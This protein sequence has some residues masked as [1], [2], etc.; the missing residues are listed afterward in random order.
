MN[1]VRHITLPDGFVAGA[2][3]CG[4]KTTEREDIAIIAAECMPVNTA[5]VTTTNQVIGAPVRWCRRILPRGFGKTRAV[6]VNAGVSNVCNGARGDK[7]AAEMAQRTASALGCKPEE[8]LVC[9]TGVIGQPLPMDKIRRGID[10]AAA[11]LGA[12]DDD[13]VARAILTTDTRPKSAVVQGKIGRTTV[14]LAGIA[15]GSGMIAPS[16]AT[17]LSFITT[18][19]KISPRALATALRVSCDSTFN[20]ITVDGDTSTSDTVAAFAS[21]LAGNKSI[22]SGDDLAR[23]GK[24]LTEVCSALAE[25]IVRDGEGA[26][27]LVRIRVRNARTQGDAKAAARTIAN[28]LLLK[29]AVHGGDPNWGRI[30]AAAGR[31]EATVD[32]DQAS[33]RIGGIAV[34]RRGTSCKFDHDAVAEHMRGDT[35]EIELDLALGTGE[36]AALTCDLSRE[37][38]EINAEY[39]T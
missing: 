2:A 38:V 29:C 26:T 14:T 33:C 12:R 30:L 9:S 27:R 13:P 23:F 24:M 37:Y 20:A 35:V 19:A 28:S 36:Y 5:V 3:R 1:E 11:G 16:M 15:K 17:M 39:H 32:Q 7:D 25:S 31:S 10:D 8:V 4:L 6:V 18:D 34:M 21:G 22:T